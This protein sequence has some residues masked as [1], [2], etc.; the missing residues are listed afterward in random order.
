MNIKPLLLA[1][2]V[3]TQAD[4]DGLSD[5]YSIKHGNKLRA[6]K[7]ATLTSRYCSAF[8]SPDIDGQFSAVSSSNGVILQCL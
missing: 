6:Q 3:A 7:D 2:S 8:A 4:G 1:L 5:F